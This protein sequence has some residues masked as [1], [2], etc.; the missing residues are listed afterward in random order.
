M[1]YAARRNPISREGK[2]DLDALAMAR[3]ARGCQFIKTPN[4]LEALLDRMCE[5]DPDTDREKTRAFLFELCSFDPVAIE[6]EQRQ[7]AHAKQVAETLKTRPDL[8]RE[9]VAR[10][11]PDMQ[12]AFHI[13]N[14]HRH[15]TD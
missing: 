8:Y 7:E 14:R 2:R 1:G 4:Q 15:A 12:R 9:L 6:A 11:P 10:L 5:K 13:L 3:I